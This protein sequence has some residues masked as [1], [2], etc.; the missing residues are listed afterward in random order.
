MFLN[1]IVDFLIVAFVIFLLIRQVN[2]LKGPPP[3]G[4]AED[5]RVPRV[6]VAGSGPGAPVLGVHVG[7]AAAD[8]GHRLGAETVV[9][10]SARAGNSRLPSWY[11]RSGTSPT[12][13][14]G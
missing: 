3:V 10:A 6:P 8:G 13:S 12:Q 2:Q 14:E 1:T 7:A 11:A 9:R 4:G 5:A